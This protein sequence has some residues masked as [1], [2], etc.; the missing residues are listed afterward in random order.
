MEMLVIYI[1][2]SLLIGFGLCYFFVKNT[3]DSNT[4]MEL[5]K[6][7]REM[8]SDSTDQL[9][10]MNANSTDQLRKTLESLGNTQTKHLDDVSRNI[11]KLKE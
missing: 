10:K 8:N 11:E 4:N 7:L 1:I 2:I 3:T 9:R 5:R 6:E